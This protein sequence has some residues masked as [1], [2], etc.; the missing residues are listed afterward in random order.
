MVSLCTFH[1]RRA[2][3]VIAPLMIFLCLGSSRYDHQQKQQ[4]PIKVFILAGQSNMV[5]EGS[6]DHLDLLMQEA[7][8]TEFKDALWNGSTYKVRDD[9]FMKYDNH[10][11]PLT[12]GRN[13]GYAGRNAFGPELMFGWTLGDEFS[14]KILLIKTA[15]GGKSL[16]VDFRPPASGQGNYTGVKPIQFGWLYRQ[17]IQDTLDALKNIADYVPNY[18]K[19]IGFQLLGFVWFQG[20]ND[21]T[22]FVM[23]NVILKP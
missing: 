22:Y 9:V 4:M 14:G 6:I 21:V 20:W 12:V 8:H 7:G 15:W 13:T 3:T 23:W 17:M 11:G 10:H 1:A 19:N 5:G 2:S 18:D 16:A